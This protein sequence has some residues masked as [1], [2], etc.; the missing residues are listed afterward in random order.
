MKKFLVSLTVLF[1][2][3]ATVH[4][5]LHDLIDPVVWKKNLKEQ[6]DR[7]NIDFSVG[8]FEGSIINGMP[9]GIKYDYDVSP[10]YL[11]HSYNRIDR[12]DINFNANIGSMVK[13]LS[14]TPISFNL[15][16]HQSLF[17]VRQFPQKMDAISAIPYSPNRLPLNAER[18]LNKL[19]VG[20]FA[21]IPANLCLV[22]SAGASSNLVNP[23]IINAGV[24]A[25]WVISG[26]FNIQIY[27]LDEKHVR[28]KMI[29]TRAY[30]RGT[31]SNTEA[32]FTV[33]GVGL[34]NGQLS[35][36]LG[37]L[38]DRDMIQLGMAANIGSQ[39]ILDYVFDLTDPAAADAYNE[40]LSSSFKFKD[41]VVLKNFGEEKEI[42]NKLFSTYE[43]ADHLYLEDSKLPTA[44][45]RVRRLF[46]GFTNST[47][48]TKHLKLGLF[49][50]S[51]T[52]DKTFSS[53]D[54]SFTD[55]NEKDTK[56][57]YPSYTH[58]TRSLLGNFL[59]GYEDIQALTC[60][61]LLPKKS[62]LTGQKIPEIGINFDRT[63]AVFT[64][65]EQHE[66]KRIINNQVPILLMK[67]VDWADWLALHNK[68]ASR[69]SFKLIINS[70]AY[71][72][73]R[74]YSESEIQ[75]NYLNY[76]SSKDIK[77]VN[78]DNIVRTLGTQ[79]YNILQNKK[80]DAE[81]SIK[82]LIDLNKNNIFSESG[83]GF[84]ASLLPEEKL[85]DLIYYKLEMLA[86]DEKTIK[87]EFGTINHEI[88]YRELA[89]LQSRIANRSYDLR[90]PNQSQ[91]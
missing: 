67:K 36:Q 37:R 13:S 45:Q 54:L 16:R 66:L 30:T 87:V 41:V 38:F 58:Y 71:P 22:I 11:P 75:N 49:L 65:K 21:S 29:T 6:L 8:F 64:P 20:D 43:K 28:L 60:F 86:L 42:K 91:P 44:N 47:S 53:S 12:Y 80:N 59:W 4:A 61:G 19:E 78:R 32:S 90:V 23:L 69:I 68:H 83:V 89:E 18:A 57:W 88:I 3:Q 48:H 26:E 81:A 33:L 51:Y 77:H 10:S 35:H 39:F 15:S 55:D 79:I 70:E 56:F 14:D 85:K 25:F 63:D 17:F 62:D 27:K 50:T 46:K 2:F 1:C 84:L 52:N 74:D 40:I 24:S 72:Y 76:V 31:N 7:T 9:L 5:S 73:L 82:E 34:L